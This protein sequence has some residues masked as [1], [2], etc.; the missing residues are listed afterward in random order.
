MNKAPKFLFTKSKLK[1]LIMLLLIS[2]SFI[3]ISPRPA[4]A[5]L[6][7]WDAE[8][9]IR[10]NIFNILK[11]LYEKGGAAAFQTTVRTALNKIAYDT[12]NWIG[13]GAQGQKPLFVT[14]GWGDY[15]A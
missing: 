11:K 15:L 6:L 5:Q 4:H 8:A 3:A 10:T 7:V 14:Q 2:F 9:S 12:A 13:S 1:A